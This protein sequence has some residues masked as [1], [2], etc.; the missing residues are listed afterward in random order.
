[1][2]LQLSLRMDR[3]GFYPRGGGI[4]TA[5]VESCRALHGVTLQARGPVQISGFSAVAGLPDTIAKRQAQRAEYTMKQRFDLKS[6]LA[7]ESWP[8]GPGTVVG[9][10]METTPV[11]VLVFALGERGKPSEKVADEATAQVGEYLRAAPAA[12]DFHSADQ[13]LLPLALADGPSEY[14]VTEVTQHLLTNIQ[15]I[16]AFLDRSIICEGEEG[17]PGWMRIA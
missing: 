16:R 4:V 12:V 9:L 2:G 8:G 11:P 14:S 15:V 10:V 6:H 17:Q 13:I 3:P 1:M 5:R 7:L